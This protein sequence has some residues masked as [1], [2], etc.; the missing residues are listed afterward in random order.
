MARRTALHLRVRESEEEPCRS[1]SCGSSVSV[2][3]VVATSGALARL[4]DAAITV[5]FVPVTIDAA[6]IAND[7]VLAG[8]QTWD[9]RVTTDGNWASAGLCARCRRA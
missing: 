4:A 9:I 3:V 6:A 8:M 2:A 1:S 5:T 7:P